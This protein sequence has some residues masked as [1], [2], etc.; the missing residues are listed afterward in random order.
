MLLLRKFFEYRTILMTYSQ[1]ILEMNCPIKI[2]KIQKDISRSNDYAK[3]LIF[4]SLIKSRAS[5]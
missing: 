3:K 4:V 1:H 5:V 2:L